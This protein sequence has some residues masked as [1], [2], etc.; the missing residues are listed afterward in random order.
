MAR[1]ARSCAATVVVGDGNIEYWDTLGSELPHPPFQLVPRQP[2]DEL[3]RAALES[4]AN[5]LRLEV[6]LPDRPVDAPGGLWRDYCQQCPATR[7]PQG[8]HATFVWP[9]MLDTVGVPRSVTEVPM[10]WQAAPADHA[11]VYFHVEW[12][13]RRRAPQCSMWRCSDEAGLSGELAALGAQYLNGDVPSAAVSSRIC[14]LG[15]AYHDPRTR[16]QR[17]RA[18][19]PLQ[20]RALW[21]QSMAATCERRR[22]ELK[23]AGWAVARQAQRRLA[24]AH[25]H[26]SVSHGRVV[27]RSKELH[28]ILRFHVNERQD[29]LRV[30]FPML[31]A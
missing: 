5:G 22:A 6:C 25:L 13:R 14:S 29:G 8:A 23:R 12:Q 24:G 4:I 28:Q 19:V 2:G 18:R 1:K 15:C 20:A 27:T 21:Q 3:A 26:E 11:V 30:S 9:G 31:P 17:H 16:R 10:S 7:I